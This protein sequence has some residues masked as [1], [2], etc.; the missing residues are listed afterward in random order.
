MLNVNYPVLGMGIIRFFDK[1]EDKIRGA[2]SHRPIVYAFIG[3]VGIIL[4]WRGVWMT[5]D[6]FDFMT[7]PVS[8]IIGVVI[9]M[10][11]GLFVSFFIDD[12]ILLSGIQEEK[13]LDEKTEEEIRGEAVS[14]RQIK[15]DLDEIKNQLKKLDKKRKSG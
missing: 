6:E 4:L 8:I 2:L 10:A 1:L 3:S 9:L 7:G 11:I 13:R 15:S 5:A 12:Q 14:L